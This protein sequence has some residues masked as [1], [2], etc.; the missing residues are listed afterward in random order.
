LAKK[1]LAVVSHFRFH[2][3]IFLT[4]TT[5]LS[6][7]FS[8]FPRLK[9]KM[10]GRHFDTVEVFE[11]KSQVVPNTFTEHDFQDAFKKRQKRWERCI[12]ATLR[13]MVVSRPKVTFDQVAL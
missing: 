8:L 2:H 7:Y 9:L 10:K 4:E 11:A 6:R 12:R 3:E 5:R 1:E 13:A